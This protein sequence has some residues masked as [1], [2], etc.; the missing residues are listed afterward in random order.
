LC[1]GGVAAITLAIIAFVSYQSSL[2]AEGKVNN[3]LKNQESINQELTSTKNRL[4]EFLIESAVKLEEDQRYGGAHEIWL[5]VLENDPENAMAK[6]RIAEYDKK[7]EV[8][9]ILFENLLVE[10]SNYYSDGNYF[11][12]KRVFSEIET[13]D[14]SVMKGNSYDSLRMQNDLSLGRIKE[15]TN[16]LLS[17]A[18]Y[19]NLNGDAGYAMELIDNVLELD[20]KNIEALELKNNIQRT[21]EGKDR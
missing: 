12:A 19:A 14:P 6:K 21:E 2:E 9:G 8:E 10:A 16:R 17:K 4:T 13:L 5:Q 15:E 11:D 18:G 20:P 1:S 3:L 7:K